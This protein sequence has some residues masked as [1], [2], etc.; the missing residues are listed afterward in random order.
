MLS[1]K[2]TQLLNSQKRETHLITLKFNLPDTF[3]KYIFDYLDNSAELLK[4]KIISENI[5]EALSDYYRWFDIVALGSWECDG[6]DE[7]LRDK[8]ECE[9]QPDYDYDALVEWAETI[10]YD[11]LNDI[12]YKVEEDMGEEYDDNPIGHNPFYKIR[13]EKDYK[14]YAEIKSEEIVNELWVIN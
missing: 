7:Y 1:K 3:V 2:H 11:H 14:E 9:Q 4:H 5:K 13:F 12:I 8:W 10:L 6:S